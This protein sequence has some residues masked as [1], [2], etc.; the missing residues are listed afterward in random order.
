MHNPHPE[1]PKEPTNPLAYIPVVIIGCYLLYVV[2]IIPFRHGMNSGER[3]AVFYTPP[4]PDEPAEVFNHQQLVRPSEELIALGARVYD[5]NCKSCYGPQGFGD[6]ASGQNLSVKPRNFHS[7]DGW[8]AGRGTVPM[9][10][11]L[12]KGIGVGMAAQVHLNP[13][14]KY[15]VIHYIHENFMTDVPPPTDAEIASLPTPSA[16]GGQITL[17][18]Y[19]E[20]RIPIRLAMMR[21][22][23][24]AGNANASG[25]P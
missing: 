9:Y 5:A 23:A 22:A 6:G 16:G 14:Q 2:I 19:A 3:D 13:R 25:Q 24:E 17:D 8:L 18:P 7:N 1:T 4:K 12:E 21:L 11:V 15:A 10:Q 20:T